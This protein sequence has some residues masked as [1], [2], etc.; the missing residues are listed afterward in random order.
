MMKANLWLAML[1]MGLGVSAASGMTE[2]ETLR[3]K[4][5][6]QERQ[7]RK[8]EDE[9]LKLRAGKSAQPSAS[10]AASGFRTVAE[11][12]PPVTGKTH[13]IQEGETFASISR[14][15]GVSIESLIAANPEAKPT[16]LRPGQV[17]R[18]SE[19]SGT[20]RT[21]APPLPPVVK[22]KTAVTSTSQRVT[23][24]PKPVQRVSESSKPLNR[25]A[26][27]SAPVSSK[28]TVTPSAMLSSAAPKSP[29][30]ATASQAAAA[31][32]PSPKADSAPEPAGPAISVGKTRAI[33]IEKEITY[34]EFAAKHGT[35]IKR[36][37]DL[38]GL[39]LANATVLAKGSELY[40]HS[41][42]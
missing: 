4:C 27:S 19:K 32:K 9:N 40:V 30:S 42:P 26:A 28:K 8:L 16:A 31:P 13:K 33:R 22:N 15:Y 5:A 24:E 2:V 21:S 36:L 39:D 34:G 17:I 10:V 29:V 12:G 38:N 3:A 23:E 20:S 37:N 1:W 11:V 25:S 18:L 35:D 6:E 41:Q 7:I 14:K